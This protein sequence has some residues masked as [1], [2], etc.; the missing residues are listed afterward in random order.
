M[1]EEPAS[2]SLL[3]G[4]T[5]YNSLEIEGTKLDRN[6][7]VGIMKETFEASSVE[8]TS[9]TDTGDSN[10]PATLSQWF[11][12]LH[13]GNAGLDHEHWDRAVCRTATLAAAARLDPVRD[14]SGVALFLKR[15]TASGEDQT[16]TANH[17]NKEF[18]KIPELKELTK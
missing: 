11:N 7:V 16:W 3:E 8:V 14:L 13:T 17:Y 4:D 2:R 5:M 12:A 18:E 10:M 15:H 9:L 6:D 1:M